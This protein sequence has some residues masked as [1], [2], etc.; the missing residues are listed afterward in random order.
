VPHGRRGLLGTSI[1]RVAGAVVPVVTRQVD[2]DEL[3]SRVDLEALL[4][5]IDL[6]AVLGRVDVDRLIARIDVQAL[7]DRVDIDG[8][9]QRVD[10]DALIQRVDVDGIIQ[11][12]DID[13]LMARAEVGDLISRSTGQVATNTLDLLRRQLAGLDVV[14]TRFVNRVLRRDP[15][16]LPDG[17]AML[18]AAVPTEAGS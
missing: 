10:V 16:S 9:V 13:A 17:P 5:R 8:I 2:A 12:V 7:I 1:D 15:A 4:A 11:R 6:D 3:L 14:A 18:V